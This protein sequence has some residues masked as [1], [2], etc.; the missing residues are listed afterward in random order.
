MDRRLW[1]DWWRYFVVEFTL[2]I[3]HD[4]RQPVISLQFHREL[5]MVLGQRGQ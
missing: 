1:F 3:A 4:E 2:E 5:G